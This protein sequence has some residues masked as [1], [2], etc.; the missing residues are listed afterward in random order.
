MQK[1][2]IIIDDSQTIRTTV[3]FAVKKLGYPIKEAEDGEEALMK[4]QSVMD[5]GDD[6][7]MVICDIN[8]PRMDGLTFVEEFRKKDRFSPIIVLTTET[9]NSKIQRA[10]ESGISGWVVKPFQ[11]EEFF[12]IVEKHLK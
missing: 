12:K 7:A 6:I 2:I 11:P 9:D 8:M 10:R 1:Y 5:N 4:I 3:E